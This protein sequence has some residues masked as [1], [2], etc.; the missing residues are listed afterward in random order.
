MSLA[1]V[2]MDNVDQAFWQLFHAVQSKLADPAIIDALPPRSGLSEA[3]VLDLPA[4][5]HALG[6]LRRE[7]ERCGVSYPELIATLSTE[8][9]SELPAWWL[10]VASDHAVGAFDRRS[11]ASPA[12]D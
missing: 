11:E 5:V 4:P 9:Q 7:A 2:N 6:V 8:R 10:A 1:E 12:A 3:V